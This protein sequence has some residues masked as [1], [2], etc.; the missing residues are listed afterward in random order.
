MDPMIA[1]SLIGAG[2]SLISGIGQTFQA[3]ADRRYHN[4][5]TNRQ[6]RREDTAVQ[7][8]VQDLKKAGLSPVLAAGSAAASSPPQMSPQPGN[9][10]TVIGDAISEIL[11]AMLQAMQINKTNADAELTKAKAE[12][13]KE[14]NRIL[15]KDPFRDPVRGDEFRNQLQARESAT[16]VEGIRRYEAQDEQTEYLRRTLNARVKQQEVSAAQADAIY[17]AYMALPPAARGTLDAVLGVIK[18]F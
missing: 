11:P 5:M 10:G 16:T 18:A 6:W 4:R 9:A 2:G 14:R 1:G 15:I 8:R 17:Q 3:D 7:R 13:E 12:L